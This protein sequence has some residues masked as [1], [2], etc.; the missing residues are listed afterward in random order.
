M[1]FFRLCPALPVGEPKYSDTG[2]DPDKLSKKNYLFRIKRL[3]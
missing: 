1:L 2:V 3:W